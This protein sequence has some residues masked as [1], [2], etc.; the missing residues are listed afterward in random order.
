MFSFKTKGYCWWK[1]SCTGWYGKYPIF[2]SPT[3]CGKT[4]ECCASSITTW[5]FCWKWGSNQRLG[6]V[7]YNLITSPLQIGYHPL[8]LT[9]HPSIWGTPDIDPSTFPF[10]GRPCP[11][12]PWRGFNGQIRCMHKTG[13]QC[14]YSRS[15]WTDLLFLGSEGFGSWFFLHPQPFLSKDPDQMEGWLKTCIAKAFRSSK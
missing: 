7:G 1:K 14:L 9:I 3:A 12:H 13:P 2:C 15:F 5:M 4:L 8:I 6:S 11:W 10:A